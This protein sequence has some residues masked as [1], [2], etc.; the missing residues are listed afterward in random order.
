M[1][2]LM[3]GPVP[4]NVKELAI[5]GDNSIV[6]RYVKDICATKATKLLYLRLINL[7]YRPVLKIELV[8]ALSSCRDFALI[9]V[10]RDAIKLPL[11]TEKS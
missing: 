4:G 5:R 8:N 6:Q 9:M 7:V 3:E 1:H 10:D 11:R 2:C